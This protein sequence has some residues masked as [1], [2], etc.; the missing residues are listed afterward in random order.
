MA[1]ITLKNI[2]EQLHKKIKQRAAQHHRSLN[3][4]I[5]AC[6]ERSLVSSPVDTDTLL[7]RARS[8]RSRLSVRLTNKDLTVLKNQGR[9]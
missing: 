4:E 2:P 7:A 6:L 8:F 5:I 9:P 3:S 1:T